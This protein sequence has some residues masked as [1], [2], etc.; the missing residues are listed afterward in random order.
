[1]HRLPLPKRAK[2]FLFRQLELG[3]NAFSFQLQAPSDI[4]PCKGNDGGV[5]YDEGST[6]TV[7]LGTADAAATSSDK[8]CGCKGGGEVMQAPALDLE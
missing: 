5:S 4:L 7:S 3:L 1:M 2:D 8:P 6:E